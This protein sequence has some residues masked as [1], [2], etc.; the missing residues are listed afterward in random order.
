V[1]SEQTGRGCVHPIH[2][3]RA[4]HSQYVPTGE[5][6]PAGR[7]VAEAVDVATG[8]SGEA[9]VKALWSGRDGCDSHILGQDAVQAS[10]ESQR[11]YS[12]FDVHMG[13]LT[14][15][16]Y[17][18]VRAAGAGHHRSLRQPQYDAE[19]LLQHT[20]HGPEALLTSPA[21]EGRSVVSQV[22]PPTPNTVEHS[23]I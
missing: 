9:G 15:S 2:L 6:V 22:Y 20:L 11:L 8:Q 14:A 19:G 3:Q 16:V 7:I 21:V 12:A 17:A 4:A 18:G 5:R 13:D 1:L 10:E 23:A